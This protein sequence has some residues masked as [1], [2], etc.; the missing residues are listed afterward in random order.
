MKKVLSQGQGVVSYR[1]KE[2]SYLGRAGGW[3]YIL[4]PIEF[5]SWVVRIAIL[6][7]V[8]HSVVP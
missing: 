1:P 4:D 7:G 5:V 8:Y 2:H 3:P 6:S